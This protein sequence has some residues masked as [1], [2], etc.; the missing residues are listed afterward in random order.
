M[1]A[2]K[3]LAVFVGNAASP[4][5]VLTALMMVTVILTN[6]MSNLAVISM[7][8]PIGYSLAVSLDVR[9]ETFI[10]GL[11]LACQLATATPIGSPCVTQTLVGGY[12]YMDYVKIGLPVTLLQAVACVLLV[13]VIYGL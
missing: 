12:K 13:P 3:V 5:V 11:T 9:P 1:I 10:I 6:F 7:F 4:V 8:L 2:D